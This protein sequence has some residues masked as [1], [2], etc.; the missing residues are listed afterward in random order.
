MR[1]A[2]GGCDAG[3]SPIVVGLKNVW[4]QSFATASG[5]SVFTAEGMLLTVENGTCTSAPSAIAGGGYNFAADGKTAYFTTWD[6]N[7]VNACPVDGCATTTTL[8]TAP[9]PNIFTMGIAVDA[10][11]AYWTTSHGEVYRCAKSGCAGKPILVMHTLAGLDAIALDD[12]NVYA[13]GAALYS[14]SKAGCAQPTTLTTSALPS[15][16]LVTDGSRLYW[17]RI[18]D[19]YPTRGGVFRC[20]VSGC[21]APEMMA[22]TTQPGGVAVDATR[23][24][25]SDTTNGTVFALAK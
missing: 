11:D 25:W 9:T 3:P 5:S 16:N 15:A 21:S 18:T 6:A 14:C 19:V 10:T 20:A 23:V 7:T 13:A 22:A 17:T 4:P 24:Y 1:C 12:V 8:W 2:K